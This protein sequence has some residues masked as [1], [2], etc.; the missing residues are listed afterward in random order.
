MF[1]GIMREEDM[2]SEK[3]IA[4]KQKVHQQCTEEL[5]KNANRFVIVSCPA[6][7]AEEYDGVFQKGGFNFVRCRHCET[8]YV[9]PRP[10]FQMLMDYQVSSREASRIWVEKI[11]PLSED[12]RRE[13]IFKPRAKRVLDLAVKHG[14]QTNK[15]V[16]VGAGFG[17]FGEEIVKLN[18][19][20]EVI[21]VES[22]A[23]CAESCRK[24]GLKVIE[25]PIEEAGLENV[26]IVTNFELIEHLFNPKDFIIACKKHLSQNGLLILSTPNSKGFDVAT[27]GA[28]SGT[29]QAPLHL[30]YFHTDSIGY[31]LESCGLEVVEILTPGLLDAE[32]VRK[33]ILNNEF[34]VSPH[35]FLRNVLIDHWD[36]VGDNFQKFLAENKLSSHM[37]AVG[38][39][40]G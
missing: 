36:R 1:G 10:T 16:D 37:L 23:L 40:R 3:Y 9:N 7:E 27:L 26:D 25:K 15:I 14:C 24:K 17:T 20:K 22:S 12:V 33:K 19:F 38:K 4:E 39:N 6:C 28:L 34:D 29:Y 8:I 21:I 30:N 13:H 5:L 18:I 32:L 35:P 31:L 2:R 11:Y